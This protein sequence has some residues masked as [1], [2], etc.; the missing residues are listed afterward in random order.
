MTWFKIDDTFYGHPKALKAGN[1]A[2]GLWAR[3]GAYAAQHLT[4][5][6]VP[7]VVAQLYGTAPQARKL[8]AAGLWHEHGHAC[9]KC[10]QPPAGDF[11]MHDFLIYNPTRD[12]VEGDRQKAAERQQRA[13]EKAADRRAQ[14]RNPSGSSA[15]RPR[16]DDDSSAE[17]LENV[18]NRGAFGDGVAGQEGPSQRDGTNP[19]RSP[20]PDPAP[21][22]PSEMQQH[23]R[24]RAGLVPELRPLADALADA[25]CAMRWGLGLGEQR[26]VH[27][28]VK[29]HGAAALAEVVTRRTAPG[30]EPKPARYWLKVWSD[31]RTWQTAGAD[32]IPL[33][34]AQPR[35]SRAQQGA[36]HLAAALARRTAGEAQ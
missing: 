19:S 14:E 3:A 5:G 7:G 10:P 23:A 21:A 24:E 12:K 15:N 25:G 9:P 30:E 6:A 32:V 22:S 34:A 17:N 16:F 29:E 13:R 2:I 31:P 35:R 26:D 36:D 18:A 8:V 20:R 33:A 11:Q 1:A 27:Q 28:L 4:E